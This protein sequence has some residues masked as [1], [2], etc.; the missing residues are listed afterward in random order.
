METPQPIDLNKLKSILGNAKKIMAVVEAKSPKAPS[1]ASAIHE[2]AEVRT[3]I[4]SEAD[5]RDPDYGTPDLSKYK[6]STYTAEQVMASNLPPAIKEAMIKNPIKQPTMASHTFTLE[7]V[8]GLA[9]KPKTKRQTISES[10][11]ADSDMITISRDELERLVDKRINEVLL[12][13]YNKTLTEQAIK[14]TISMLIKEGKIAVKK[15]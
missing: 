6:P 14:K 13:S 1:K 8:Q 5:E 15:K 7:D 3:P 2:E 11:R 9:E 12:Q 10:H 4:Y